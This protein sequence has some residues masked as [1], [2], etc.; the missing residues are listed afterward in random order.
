LRRSRNSSVQIQQ[1]DEH[2]AKLDRTHQ[3]RNGDRQ[4]GGRDVIKILRNGLRNAQSYAFDMS[5][6]RW[7]PSR[8]CRLRTGS[9]S[10]TPREAADYR[11]KR[12]QS[13][14]ASPPRTLYRNPGR[15][16]GP[17]DTSASYG[18]SV[19]AAG[20]EQAIEKAAF[21]QQRLKMRMAVVPD[22]ALRQIC[23]YQATPAGSE[24]R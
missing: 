3:Q 13:S 11:P 22:F 8:S 1:A 2:L 6:H 21:L 9:A 17:R 4:A 12:R 10:T 7:C 18:S 16:A 20:A 15:T 14:R 24:C 5:T 23:R 19:S